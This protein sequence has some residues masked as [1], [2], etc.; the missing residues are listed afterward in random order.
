MPN[1]G[2][3]TIETAHVMLGAPA[4]PEEPAPGNYLAV[5]VS[6]TGPGIPDSVRER[7]FE[8]FFTTKGIGKGSGLGLSQVL[9][10]VKQLGGGLAVRSAAGE[11]TC[12]SLYLPRATKDVPAKLET[13]VPEA[14]ATPGSPARI[15]LVDD[16]AD[17][18][19]TAAAMLC[20]AGYEVTE[21][22]SGAAALDALERADNR[23]DLVLA[24]IAM[25]GINGVEF[26][27]IVRRTWPALPVLLMTGYAD[28]GLLRQ[29]AEHD[30]LRKP[31]RVIELEAKLRLA[32]ARN[33][34]KRTEMGA[35]P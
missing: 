10:V 24:D 14:D 23:T 31:F 11:G 6:D 12:I 9:G 2:A 17:V 18:R 22:S 25:P 16:D 32:L 35:I 4:W 7:M 29:G 8:P 15:L 1:G 28:S 30:V 20:E 3:I 21:A 26:A 34:L 19:S 27:A 33:W 5:R 13:A